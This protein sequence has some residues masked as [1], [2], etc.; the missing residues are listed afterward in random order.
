MKDSDMDEMT[1]V[2]AIGLCALIG[3]GIGACATPPNFSGVPLLML[4]FMLGGG[5]VAY[6]TL[7]FVMPKPAAPPPSSPPATHTTEAPA[8]VASD[9]S[10][11]IHDIL[12]SG[13]E[14]AL[15]V[16][17]LQRLTEARP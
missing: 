5:G 7:L 1:R 2:L 11:Q 10:R 17:E 14:P 12:H 15:I 9:M 16:E 4:G 6:V 8:P 13:S 3:L